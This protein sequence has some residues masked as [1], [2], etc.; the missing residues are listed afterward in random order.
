MSQGINSNAL[1]V[2]DSG[3]MQSPNSNWWNYRQI[4]VLDASPGG[5]G[6][7][8]TPPDANTLGGY[9][10][11]ADDEFLYFGSDVHD[12]WD[13]SSDI[14]VEVFFETN[15]ENGG[16]APTDTVDLK[17]DFQLKGLN[18]NFCKT[19]IVETSVTVGAVARFTLFVAEFLI[20]Y[21]HGALPVQVGDLISA[22]LNLETDTSEV[23]DVII[24]HVEF[25]YK[26]K[27][28][29]AIEVP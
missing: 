2:D 14:V 25:K 23:D 4:S 9:R 15:I 8:F 5:S 10:F 6:A 26:S 22:T 19:H 29:N 16:G 3:K 1:V 20:D 13:E 12:D 17:I 18:E 24:T 7:T 28:P 11:D 21:D 27:Q